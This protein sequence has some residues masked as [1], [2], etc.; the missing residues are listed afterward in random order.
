MNNVKVLEQLKED[1]LNYLI[2]KHNFPSTV[3]LWT[4]SKYIEAAKIFSELLDRPISSINS[5]KYAYTDRYLSASTLERIFKYGYKLPHPIDKRRLNTINKLS[6]CLGYENFDAFYFEFNN[7]LNL[8][9]EQFIIKANTAEFE[10]YKNLPNKNF[11]ILLPYFI[12]DSPAY[13]QI[14]KLINKQV[15]KGVSLRDD[16]NPSYF[17]VLEVEVLKKEK[18]TIRIKTKECWYLKWYSK[19][20]NVDVNYYNNNN[21]QL[22]ILNKTNEGWKININHYP[23]NFDD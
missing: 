13:N 3:Q 11:D 14:Y 10:T 9:F 18:E 22:Y 5:N 21:T 1:L 19:N 2:E 23:F 7:G 12:K 20:E 16:K 4:R 8:D 6:Q 15:K 17:E